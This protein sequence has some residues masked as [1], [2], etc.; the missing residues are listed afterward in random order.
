MIQEILNTARRIMRENG[1][2]SLTMNELARRLEIKPPS[3]YNYFSGLM[4]IYDALFRLGFVMWRE[5]TA[6]Q[7]PGAQSWQEVVRR[8]METYL[9]FA[10]ENPELYQLC[11]ERPV[12]GFVPSEQSLQIS[13]GILHQSYARFTGLLPDMDTDL[14]SEQ[15]V[16][17]VIAIAHGI[18]AQHMAN[19]PHLA[20][21]EGRFGSLIPAALEVLE[22]AWAK[23]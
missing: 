18:T 8:F 4:D 17:L 3:L 22:K 2:A 7:E 11:F 20:L 10:L 23:T 19:E 1:A 12:P 6:E 5:R 14:Q 21:G 13:Y 15:V 9:A 16:D